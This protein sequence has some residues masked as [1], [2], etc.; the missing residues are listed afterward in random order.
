MT[1]FRQGIDTLATIAQDDPSTINLDFY[2]S[3][4]KVPS[5]DIPSLMN[6]NFR[7]NS[8]QFAEVSIPFVFPLGDIEYL[9]GLQFSKPQSAPKNMPDYQIFMVRAFHGLDTLSLNLIYS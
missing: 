6:D 3:A 7:S 5:R 1:E 2:Y 9:F 4:A 8:L